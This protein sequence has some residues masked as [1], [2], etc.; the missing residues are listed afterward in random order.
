MLFHLVL[1]GVIFQFELTVI[2]YNAGP[3]ATHSLLLLICKCIYFAIIFEIQFPEYRIM[4][5]HPC[6]ITLKVSFYCLLDSIV[7]D[8]KSPF[9]FILFPKCIIY[10]SQVAF[11]IF[12][13]EFTG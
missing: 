3:Q 4:S 10:C 13:W 1:S 5:C 8:K 2:S 12:P 11:K 6:F 9:F 7:T